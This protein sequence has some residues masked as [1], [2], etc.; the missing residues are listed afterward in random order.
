[1]LARQLDQPVQDMT[2]LP[3]N[4]NL[5]LE[6]MPTDAPS[7]TGTDTSSRPTFFTALKEQLGLQLRPR[8]VTI[9]VLV[10]D[11]AERVPTEN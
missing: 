10:V 1:M 9:E 4:Y 2:G 6:W 3:G 5:K 11:H 7:S 8:K